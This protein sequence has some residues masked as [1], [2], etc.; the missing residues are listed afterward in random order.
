M[1]RARHAVALFLS[2]GIAAVAGSGTATAA[3]GELRPSTPALGEAG[4]GQ[5]TESRHDHHAASSDL[6]LLLVLAQMRGHLLAAEE[7]LNR[8]NGP[9]AE[10]HTG[11]PVDELY[12]TIEAALQQRRIAPFLSTLEALRQQVRLAPNSP[13]SRQ[14]LSEA[15]AAIARCEAALPAALRNNPLPAQLLARELAASATSEYAGA[16][17]DGRILEVIEYQDGRGFLRQADLLLS[18]ARNQSSNSEADRSA[19]TRLQLQI[20]AMLRAFPSIDP[21]Q[22]AVMSAQ[23]LRRLQPQP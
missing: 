18:T 23:Q 16:E 10:P 12:G 15:R 17:D 11:H 22:R 19:L 9:A 2:L 3:P 20:R 4:A 7:L 1:P 6:Q 13:L 8:G 14:R 21:P 5:R